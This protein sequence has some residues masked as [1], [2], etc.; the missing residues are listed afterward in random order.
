MIDMGTLIARYESRVNILRTHFEDSIVLYLADICFLC[1]IQL[2]SA[3]T[4]F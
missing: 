1:F 4:N 2:A 3:Y